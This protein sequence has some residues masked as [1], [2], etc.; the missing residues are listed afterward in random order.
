MSDK[1]TRVP[2]P[3][4][5]SPRLIP[6]EGHWL[7]DIKASEIRVGDVVCHE[8]MDRDSVA[9]DDQGEPFIPAY[10]CRVTEASTHGQYRRVQYRALVA[11]QEDPPR[12]AYIKLDEQVLLVDGPVAAPSRGEAAGDRAAIIAGLRQLADLL[13]QVAELPVP[14]YGHL[15][16]P[17]GMRDDRGIPAM[18]E[19]A[20]A[21]DEHGVPYVLT[22]TDWRM[23]ISL[24]LHGLHVQV[25]QVRDQAIEEY[26]QQT[27]YVPNVQVDAPA[28]GAR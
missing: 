14:P 4:T 1:I 28:G 25:N 5:R 27:S 15:H 6:R 24:H 2:V 26:V 23:A 21:L 7:G 8:R 18:Q 16:W 11:P 10:E 17:L 13:E 9:V 20:R 12:T 22:D 3:P 19:A